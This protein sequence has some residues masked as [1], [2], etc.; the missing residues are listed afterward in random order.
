M[1]QEKTIEVNKIKIPP[2]AKIKVYWDDKP[3][4]YSR[5]SR[6]RVKKYFSNKY[7]IPPQNINVVYRPVRVNNTGETI[8][9]DGATLDN[10]MTTSY[11]RELFKEWLNREG[12]EV[13][14]QRIIALDDKVNSEL[15]IEVEEKLYR[16]YKLSW[17][18]INNFLSFGENN[19]FPIDKFR[20]LVV[21]NSNPSNQGGKTTLTIDA[22]KYLFFGKTTKTD[23]NE[24]VFNQF[25]ENQ[26]LIVRGMIKIEGEDDFIIERKLERKSKRK[27]GWNITNKL[28]YYKI[29]PDGE[30]E[31]MNDEDAIKTTE[32][33]KDTVGSE[34]DFDLMVLATSRNLDDLVDST[35]GESGKMLTRFIGLEILSEKEGIVRKMYNEYNKTMKSNIYDVETLSEE[36]QIHKVNLIN[37]ETENEN[38]KKELDI[39]KKVYENL[40]NKKIELISSKEKIDE[41]ILT[42]NPENLEKEINSIVEKGKEFKTKIKE[43]EVSIK[44]IGIIKFDEDKDFKLN[45]DKTKLSGQVEVKKA[46]IIRLNKV[47]EDLIKGGICQSCNRVLDNVDNSEHINKHNNDI[48]NL[49]NELAIIER[50]LTNVNNEISGMADIKAKIELKNKL[51]LQKDRVEVEI[52]SLRNTLKDKNSDLNKYN[53]NIDAIEKNKRIDIE[54]SAV[55]TKIA[56]SENSKDKI[57]DKL[58]NIAIQNDS[59]SKDIKLKEGLIET[60][61]KEKEI[62]KIFKVYIDMIGKKGISKLILRSVLPIINGELQRLL[63][64]ITDFEV[65]IFI[66]DKNEVRYLL[67]KDGVEKPLKSG[68]GYELTASS[69]ALRC[70]LG[71]MSSLPMPNFIT[72]DEVLG[73]VAAEN[74]PN[75]KPLFERISDMYDIIFFITQIDVVKDWADKI[76]TVNK[77][78]NISSIKIN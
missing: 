73:R 6:S 4:N 77:E 69:I 9:I 35:A 24:E 45:N 67:I 68:S 40:N 21:V 15:E 58:K 63:E 33:I 7:G 71:K 56:V 30:E 41:D 38:V 5:E 27:G 54:V 65:E 8:K 51:E 64:D 72:F 61:H 70:V 31:E 19:Y 18:T 28:S 12:K 55:Q 53:Q 75:M 52:D 50:K 47:V 44:D 11:Q 36:I 39:E 46:E 59:N 74:I 22:I 10:I 32:L 60:I 3:E 57:N 25:N 34:K 43:L 29:F 20:G 17:L 78:N 62:D 23:K 13:D 2:Y 48:E 26:E 49:K 37:L 16:K 42:M 76:I 66:D 14:F 1:E